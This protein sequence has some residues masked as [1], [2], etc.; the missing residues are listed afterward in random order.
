MF[1]TDIYAAEVWFCSAHDYALVFPPF[2]IRKY[3][4]CFIFYFTGSYN[5]ETW[6]FKEDL[7]L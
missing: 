7:G 5:E 2:R 3:V 4:S 1:Y 6:N